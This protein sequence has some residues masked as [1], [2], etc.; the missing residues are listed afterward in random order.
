MSSKT[1]I[2]VLHMKEIIYTIIFA[3][4]GILILCLLFFMFSGGKKTGVSGKAYT[5]GV[6]TSTV[7]LNNTDLEVEV[8]VDASR[9]NS[10]RI[11]NLSETVT[12]MYPLVRPTAEELADQ[13]CRT[14]SLENIELSKDNP[15]TS[16]LLL[17][18]IKDALQKAKQR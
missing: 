1:K 3:A 4:L 11:S 13:I 17:G 7:T 2:I 8:A 18:A 9:I 5:P 6:Y 16:Q 10:I 12:A 15:Y 14:Q